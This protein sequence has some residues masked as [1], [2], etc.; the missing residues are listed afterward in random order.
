M[1]EEIDQLSDDQLRRRLAQY[2]FA[3]LPV[4]DTTRKVLVKKLKNAIGSEKDKNRRE[5]V[6]VSKFSSDDEPEKEDG[7]KGRGAKTPSR[8]ATVALAEKSSVKK[9]N[10]PTLGNVRA[11]TPTKAPPRRASR[12]TPA[13]QEPIAVAAAAVLQED[14]DDDVIEVPLKRRSSSRTTTPTLG[15]S[16]TVRTSYKTSVDVV[17]ENEGEDSSNVDEPSIEEEFSPPRKPSPVF[18]QSASRRKPF[19]TSSSSFSTKL[20]EKSSPPKFGKPSLTTSYNRRGT[21]NS[22]QHDDYEEPE[23][24]ESDT[25]YLSNFAKRLST[26]RAEPLDSGMEKYKTMT[27]SASS[28]QYKSSYASPSYSYK[29]QAAPALMPT[30]RKR[31]ILKDLGQIFDSLD[32]QYNFRTILY[33]I[34]IVMICV[35][36]YVLFM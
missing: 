21:Y 28:T 12:A 14:S 18:T 33:I 34:F 36:I 32:R 24:N 1:T 35:A 15:K 25:P 31:G 5:T 13:K 30:V 11:E 26:L 7:S 19:T 9:L 3:N 22:S 6:A 8:R 2:G 4:T 27:P 10:G 23:L 16:D 17:E 20:P 29:T